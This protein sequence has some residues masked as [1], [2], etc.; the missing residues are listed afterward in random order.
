LYFAWKIIDGNKIKRNKVLSTFSKFVILKMFLNRVDSTT[1]FF[2]N[3]LEQPW[4]NVSIGNSTVKTNL[5]T[6]HKVQRY[7]NHCF[8]LDVLESKKILILR[9][10]LYNNACCFFFSFKCFVINHVT[11]H[12]NSNPALFYN[13]ALRIDLFCT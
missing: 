2:L 6:K 9:A 13:N 5:T 8:F 3:Q 7:K 12:L 1:V 10:L 4:K 11:M